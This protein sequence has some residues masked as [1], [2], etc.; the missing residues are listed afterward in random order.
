MFNPV[1]HKARRLPAKPRPPNFIALGHQS[2]V[3]R[4]S[5]STGACPGRSTIARD[6]LRAAP[7]TVPPR[8][9]PKAATL[10]PKPSAG[11]KQAP[12]GLDIG[13]GAA[14]S[15][16]RPS[17]GAAR[18]AARPSAG[19]LREAVC[20]LEELEVLGR[21]GTPLRVHHYHMGS[22]TPPHGL[23]I[24]APRAGWEE[25]PPSTLHAVTASMTT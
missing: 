4:P 22:T 18:A 16:R 11:G 17:A 12:R 3:R 19:A 21:D 10:A 15:A 6:P 8:A 14:Q 1:E 9:K 20:E 24:L 13:P 5:P 7:S 23:V 2:A 25:C